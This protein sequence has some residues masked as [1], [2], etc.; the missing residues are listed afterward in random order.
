[1]SDGKPKATG[2]WAR[3]VG[4]A[5]SRGETAAI[6]AMMALSVPLAAGAVIASGTVGWRWWQWLIVLLLAADLGGGVV[7]NALP[8]T[9]RWYHAPWVPEWR[10]LSFAV[11]HL[12]LPLMALLV[13][14]AMPLQAAW[15][16]YAWMIGGAAALIAIPA[17][18]RLAAAF[19]L[20]LAGTTL[21]ARLV[22][23]DSAVGWMPLALMLKILA[24]HLIGPA[25]A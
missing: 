8:A 3:I 10:H 14:E 11:I 17:R 15:L 19:V 5:T 24:G 22:P 13:P 4:P 21:M 23:L 2:L 12:H 6:L 16:G 20:T 1:M 18:W 9:K 25:R 7:A